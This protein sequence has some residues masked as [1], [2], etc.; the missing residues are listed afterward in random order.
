MEYTEDAAMRYCKQNKR[1]QPVLAVIQALL[2]G[3]TSKEIIRQ[4]IAPSLS[5][6]TIQYYESKYR[7]Q[8][9]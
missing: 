8:D 5:I 2:D 9:N 7:V 1:L 6:R 3:L 4:Q